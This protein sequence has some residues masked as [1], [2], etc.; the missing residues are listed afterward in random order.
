MISYVSNKLGGLATISRLFGITRVYG[1]QS[2]LLVTILF[3]A[4]LPSRADAVTCALSITSCGCTISLSGDYTLSG[5]SPMNSAGTCINITASNVTLDGAGIVM[6]GPGSTSPTFG[7]HIESTANKVFLEELAV[8]GFGQGIRIDGLNA[9]TYDV[10][11]AL[12]NKGVV[13]NGANAYLITA[14]SEE[15]NLAGIQVN[16]TA[17]GLVAGVLAGV[18]DIGVGIEFNGVNGA[19]INEAEG[20]GDGTFGIWLKSASH[21]AISGFQ[22]ESN[23]VAGVYLGCN[24]AGPNGTPCPAGV[25]SSDYN[26]LM[27]SVY[28]SKNSLVSNTTSPLNQRFGIAVGLGNL[29]NQFLEVTGTGNVDDDALDENPNCASNRWAFDSFTTSSPAKGT[30]FFCLN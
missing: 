20:E 21:N 13:V 25:P 4:V 14:I 27:G 12:N 5:T 9:I 28:A 26:S 10:V 7:V 6:K 24:A 19:F 23:G 8:E 15:D 30:T 17:T 16:S 22:A 1:W 2:A 18:D 3:A 11:T 29:H